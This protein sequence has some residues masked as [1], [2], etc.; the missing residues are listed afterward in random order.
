LVIIWG[1]LLAVVSAV[2]PPLLSRLITWRTPGLCLRLIDF[3]D[4]IGVFVPRAGDMFELRKGENLAALALAQLTSAPFIGLFVLLN[5]LGSGPEVGATLL[6]G[7]AIGDFGAI[8]INRRVMTRLSPD[9]ALL[10]EADTDPMAER[11]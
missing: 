5:A 8:L 3:C 4:V 1:V 11:P 6:I 2:S 7:I 10:P 9:T